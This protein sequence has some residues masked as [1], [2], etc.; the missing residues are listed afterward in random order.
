MKS[1]K[2][3]EK[4]KKAQGYDPTKP[5]EPVLKVLKVPTCPPKRETLPVFSEVLGEKVYFTG[6]NTPT[7]GIDGV[8]YSYEELKTIVELKPTP[9]ELRLLHYAKVAFDGPISKEEH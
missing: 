5:T 4:L 7:D 9:H 1:T 3:R 8:V 2:W 6:A